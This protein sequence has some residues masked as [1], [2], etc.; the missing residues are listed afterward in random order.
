MSNTVTKSFVFILC[1]ALIVYLYCM[2][3]INHPYCMY[4]GAT[5]ISTYNHVVVEINKCGY[6]YDDCEKKICDMIEKPNIS[7]VIIELDNQ[8][9]CPVFIFRD[10][11]WMLL[12]VFILVIPFMELCMFIRKRYVAYKA[13]K[14]SAIEN[15]YYD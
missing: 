10:V 13:M 14:D 9:E 5:L 1:L 6:Y 15:D 4:N 7:N 3:R 12:L 8:S 11:I 2:D